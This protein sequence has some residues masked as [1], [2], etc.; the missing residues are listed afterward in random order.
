MVF[1]AC[2]WSEFVFSVLQWRLLVIWDYFT[3]ATLNHFPPT[4]T[5]FNFLCSHYFSGSQQVFGYTS[6]ICLFFSSSLQIKDPFGLDILA[7]FKEWDHSS[8]FGPHYNSIFFSFFLWNLCLFLEYGTFLP[9]LILQLKFYMTFLH[10]LIHVSI[11]YFL[12]TLEINLALSLLF[13][14]IFARDF[15]E[16]MVSISFMSFQYYLKAATIL[17]M[18]E[19]SIF[20]AKKKTGEKMHK[21]FLKYAKKNIF[22]ETIFVF[23]Y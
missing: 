3:R 15:S 22:E 11:N 5:T 1:S 10:Q 16:E 13:I 8:W 21:E 9:F 23:W 18:G 2:T 7:A 12:Q 6:N 17:Y 14:G 19:K 4:E 20:K